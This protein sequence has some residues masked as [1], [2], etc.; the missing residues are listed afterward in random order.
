MMK[1]NC[2]IT[3]FAGYKAVTVRHMAGRF[4]MAVGKHLMC[5][6]FS[7][8]K[9]VHFFN[10]HIQTRARTKRKKKKKKTPPPIFFFYLR[11]PISRPPKTAGSVAS[12]ARIGCISGPLLIPSKAPTAL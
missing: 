5:C 10:T 2:C 9:A 12:E 11:N 1:G 7:L 3:G 8:S 4:P 6:F